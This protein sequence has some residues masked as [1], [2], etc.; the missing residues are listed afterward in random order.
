MIYEHDAPPG[1]WFWVDRIWIALSAFGVASQFS[2]NAVV[3]LSQRLEL[4]T[5]VKCG[6]KV[7]IRQDGW[8]RGVR[9]VDEEIFDTATMPRWWWE[10]EMTSSEPVIYD[11]T[12]RTTPSTVVMLQ[13]RDSGGGRI[14]V[15][16]EVYCRAFAHS[17]NAMSSISFRS[18]MGIDI[19]EV[20][21]IPYGP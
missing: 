19:R 18:P 6:I 3:A 12:L 7:S 14:Q 20:T 10:S 21:L 16:V 1:N 8:H 2:G 13:G 11:E 17:K 5:E 15:H 4:R 9:I